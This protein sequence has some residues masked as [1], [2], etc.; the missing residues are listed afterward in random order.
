ME[1]SRVLHTFV[2]NKSFPHLL[3]IAQNIFIFLETFKSEFSYIEILFTD[4]YSKPL[5]KE[6]KTNINSVI[7]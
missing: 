6:D 2:S 5:E 7:N 1:D 4:Q 3:D